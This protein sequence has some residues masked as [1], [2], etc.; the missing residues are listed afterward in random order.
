M[1]RRVSPFQARYTLATKL[2]STRSTLLKVDC[3]RN[4][5]QSRLLPYTFN[6]VADT[7]N[8]VA[9]LG[10]KSWQQ[11]EFDSLSRS[12]LS[13]LCTGPQRHG[14][15]CRL[16]TKSTVLNSTLSPVYTGRNLEIWVMGQSTSL[17]LVPFE[18]LGTVSYSPSIVT[19]AVSCIS[20]KK[21]TLVENCDF[22]NPPCIGRPSYGVPV[23][24]F[25]IQNKRSK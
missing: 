8:F 14:R 11:L 2:N 4:R 23:I 24:P 13:P 19:M 7:F 10:N 25:G 15:L 3:C 18:S 17:K 22:F 5:Q 16:S 12:T 20:E 1:R 6:F 21:D 9:G